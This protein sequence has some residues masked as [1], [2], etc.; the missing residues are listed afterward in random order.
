MG[1]WFMS[2]INEEFIMDYQTRCSCVICRH[3]TTT[4]SLNRHFKK[5]EYKEILYKSCKKCGIL[6]SKEGP[7][8]SRSCGNSRPMSKEQKSNISN[9]LKG[10]THFAAGQKLVFYSKVSQCKI[11]NNWFKGHRKTCSD[12]CK[13]LALS[14]GG[15]H[16]ASLNIKRSLDEIELFNFCNSTFN[17]V[18]HN[19]PLF[20]GWDADIIIHDY[21]L[22]ILWNGPWHYKEMNMK[23]HSLLQVQN[24]DYLK[25]SEIKKYGYVPLVFED[26]HYTPL[27][28]FEEIMKRALDSNQD[29]R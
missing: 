17:K 3:E 22:A 29:K 26:R 18:E 14:K 28:A 4:Q 12:I 25:I 10:T 23:N 1:V 16:S 6:H 11:C 13:S 7:F 19:V 5:H 2:K 24:R 8:C 15:K 9:T 20:N 21:K 27:S